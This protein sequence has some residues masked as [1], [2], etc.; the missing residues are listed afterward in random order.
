MTNHKNTAGI[1][2]VLISILIFL[3]VASCDRFIDIAPPATQVESVKLFANEQSAVAA[4]TGIY[5]TLGIGASSFL[6]GGITLYTAA[7][8]D[9][10]IATAP[11]T[12]LDPF[13]TNSI[14]P[15]H[16]N[17]YNRLWI[18]IYGNACIYSANAII[19][20]LNQSLSLQ[21]S[22]KQKL[23]A[24]AKVIR[25]LGYFYLI[26][27]YGDVPYTLTTDYRENALLP[28]HT[29]IDIYNGIKQDL[30]DAFNILNTT[31]ASPG[32]ARINKWAACA[33][34]ARTYLYT[35][36]WNNALLYSDKIINS[37]LY[38]LNENLESIFTNTNST[39]TIWH[40]VRDNAPTADG[41]TFIPSSPTTRP[42]YV[43]RASLLSAFESSDK[44]KLA[45]ISKNTI[46]GTDYYFPYKYK[47]RTATQPT[48]YNLILRLAEQYLIRAEARVNLGDLNGA[49]E[50]LNAIR[51]RA[52]LASLAS[53]TKQQLFQW[54][55][56][57]RQKELF[58][59]M[60]HRWFDL[61]RTGKIDSVLSIEKGNHWQSTDALFP[62]PQTE[63]DR[64]P[65]LKQNPGY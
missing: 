17:L 61:K 24:E 62:I 34:L 31:Y 18:P 14:T 65:F 28:R 9:E 3:P 25:S 52:G 54:I 4:V 12:D 19:A 8:S 57:E 46:A 50:D 13:F 59:E 35:E 5:A 47:S 55:M 27:M 32:K 11:N 6:N 16:P 60:G 15:A 36:D 40:L 64:N 22:V 23:S 38:K 10:I 21:D 30:I 20:G 29:V 41:S 49:M 2:K 43:I 39:E 56:N 51:K 1:L 63:I 26:N 58:C 37:G 7:A 42:V 53:L 33:L 48:E 44:R 45:W